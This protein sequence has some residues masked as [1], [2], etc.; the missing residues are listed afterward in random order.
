MSHRLRGALRRRGVQAAVG[1]LV[2]TGALAGV[3]AADAAE[4]AT[5]GTTTEN[6]WNPPTVNIATG[7]SVTWDFTGSTLAHNVAAVDGPDEDTTWTGQIVPFKTSGT[8][9]RQ[10]NFPGTYTYLCQAHPGM[11]GTIVVAGEPTEPT[12]TPTTDP[13]EPTPTPTTGPG[14]P[15][16]TPTPGTG[17]PGTTPPGDMGA[18]PAPSGS[19]AADRTAPAITALKLKRIKRGARV[20]FTL[21]EPA[22]VTLTVRKGEKT[23]RTLR[24]Q[25]RSG[26]HKVKVRRLGK[27]RR[28]FALQ[29]RDA[30]GN[31]SDT[32]TA[33]I[34]VRRK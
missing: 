17:G 5:V 11:D 13:G 34:R 14:E 16:P 1:S 27:G 28:A 12:P 6:R 33:T 18:T 2:V 31:R 19:A 29:A 20:A 22:S 4:D 7:E 9:S 30:A 3:G 15:T 32:A 21:S 26:A 8:A 23:L 10:F 24:L 25:V